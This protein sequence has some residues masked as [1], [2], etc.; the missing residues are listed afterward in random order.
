MR[1]I[2]FFFREQTTEQTTGASKAAKSET[3]TARPSAGP[4]AGTSLTRPTKPGDGRPAGR[5]GRMR[6]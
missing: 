3:D 5:R 6:R 4:A 1:S 2:F